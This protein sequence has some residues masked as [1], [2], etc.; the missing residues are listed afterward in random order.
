MNS[1]MPVVSD[2][3]A[4]KAKRTRRK[5]DRP[6]QLLEAALELF[7]EKGF[8]ATRAEEIA[9]KAGVSKGTLFLYF[10]SKEDLLKAVVR[11]NI[12]GHF[13]EWAGIFESFEGDSTAMLR[14]AV[15]LWWERVGTTKASGIFKLI[16]SEAQN[17]PEIAL[18]YQQ[19]VLQPVQQWVR[20]ILQRGI[21]KGEFR[22]LD[23]DYAAFSITAPLLFL[24]MWQNSMGNCLAQKG[25][26]GLDA[27][28]YIES[29]LDIILNG[30]TQNT[31]KKK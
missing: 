16:V 25:F 26:P 8:S 12:L 29:Q 18:F 28:R 21:E 7:V 3:V 2:D 17:F 30:F 9:A 24:T 10:D 6:G 15:T 27:T 23:L 11:E 4:P 20:L 13:K 5:E 22:A 14:S 31:N 1:V 19:E